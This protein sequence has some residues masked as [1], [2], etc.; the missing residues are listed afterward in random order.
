MRIFLIGFMGSG[1]SHFGKK[2]ARLLNYSFIDIDTYI[3]EQNNSSVSDIFEKQGEDFFRTQEKD[4]L[5]TFIQQDNIVVA[6]GGGTPCFHNNMETMNEHGLTVY[7]KGS[8]EFLY[9][10]ILPGKKA[11]P[12]ISGLE[13]GELRSFIGKT[14]RV[15][16]PFYEQAKIIL[17]IKGLT[18]KA[19]MEKLN[20]A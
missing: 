2:L 5:K 14:L 10:R 12:L 8:A 4:A 18:P 17:D 20:L 19:I 6:T 3:S 7:L 13:E 1:K 9:H 11:R 15:R 16:S